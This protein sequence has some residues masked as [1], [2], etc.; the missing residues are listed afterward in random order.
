MSLSVIEN[1]L[2]RQTIINDVNVVQ[3]LVLSDAEIGGLD[4]PVDEATIMEEFHNVEDLDGKLKRSC[5]REP[6]AHCSHQIEQIRPE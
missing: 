2:L 5:D 3:V 6:P 1:V 4:V